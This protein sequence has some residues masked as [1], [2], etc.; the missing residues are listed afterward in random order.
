LNRR[1]EYTTLF[2]VKWRKLKC[3]LI[4]MSNDINMKL[5]QIVYNI[6]KIMFK[7]K[8]INMT[9][10]FHNVA[11]MFFLKFCQLWRVITPL[12]LIVT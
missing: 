12:N 1:C 6:N 7:L 2:S 9:S 4:E 11:K 3:K 5:S 10:Y 8:K